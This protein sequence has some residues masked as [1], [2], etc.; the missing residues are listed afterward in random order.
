M[1]VVFDGLDKAGKTTQLNLISK[2]LEGKQVDFHRTREPGGC[3]VSEAIRN[4]FMNY[5]MDQFSRLA[6]ISAARLEHTKFLKENYSNKLIIC[7]RFIDS[8]IAYQGKYF[9]KGLLD[10]F[11]ENSVKLN[12]DYVFLFLN[13]Y[14]E[15]EDLMDKEA[16]DNRVEMTKIFEKR[17]AEKKYFIVPKGSVDFV[18]N[19]I[20]SKFEEILLKT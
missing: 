17:A 7:D 1:F 9:S 2:W 8:T 20:I 4:I 10:V 19:F 13:A 16:F 14:A 6:L 18:S 11:F 12:P 3:D 15:P 5:E